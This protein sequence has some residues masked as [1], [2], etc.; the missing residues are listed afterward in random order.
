MA[1]RV[2][3]PP[4]MLASVMAV[5]SLRDLMLFE[6]FYV[7]NENTKYVHTARSTRWS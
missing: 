1:G 6:L 3:S 4:P 2:K 5:G 7:S